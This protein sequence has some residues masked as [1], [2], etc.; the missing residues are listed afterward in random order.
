MAFPFQLLTRCVISGESLDDSL[1]QFPEGSGEMTAG[2]RKLTKILSLTLIYSFRLLNSLGIRAGLLTCPS[3][4]RPSAA[5]VIIRE[6]AMRSRAS[7]GTS[8]KLAPADKGHIYK[9]WL[10]GSNSKL[11]ERPETN[12]GVP[13]GLNRWD[14]HAQPCSR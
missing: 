4:S 6:R 10:A 12:G 8:R 11:G 14:P 7:G 5:Q 3:A 1:P 13:G 2:L 9:R